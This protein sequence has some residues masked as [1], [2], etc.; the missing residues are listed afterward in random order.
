MSKKKPS[1]IRLSYRR[2]HAN[3]LSNVTHWAVFVAVSILFANNLVMAA[4]EMYKGHQKPPGPH[5][6][7]AFRSDPA[8]GRFCIT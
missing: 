8:P 1:K 3:K 5:A 4:M 2:W 6:Q 7:A